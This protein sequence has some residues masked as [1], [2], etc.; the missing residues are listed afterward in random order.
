MLQEYPPS[1]LSSPAR[2]AHPLP[3]LFDQIVK[4]GTGFMPAF[5]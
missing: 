4:A 3:I 5:S 2:P 1:A